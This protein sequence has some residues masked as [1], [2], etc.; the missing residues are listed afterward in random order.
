[1]HTK[2]NVSN[3]K[4]HSS[5]GASR[6]STFPSI[7]S[8]LPFTSLFQYQGQ[9][10][11]SKV[12]S[13]SNFQRDQTYSLTDAQRKILKSTQ[14]KLPRTS[15][16]EIQKPNGILPKVHSAKVNDKLEMP[17]TQTNALR[18]TVH[19][20]SP[21]S[22]SDKCDKCD[23]KCVALL[24]SAAKVFQENIPLQIVPIIKSNEKIILMH[25]GDL[26]SKWVEVHCFRGPFLFQLA[27]S[28]SQVFILFD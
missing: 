7:R 4:M 16:G 1:M 24:F 21:K 6:D 8:F 17:L 5:L 2:R 13:S 10:D 23:G 9:V 28:A 18:S 12:S 22:V 25:K 3:A 27:L 20:Q 11:K 19:E 26:Q 14:D 15:K